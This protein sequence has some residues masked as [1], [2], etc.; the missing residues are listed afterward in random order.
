[1]SK[2]E[3][4]RVRH[5][6]RRR[7][8]TVSAVER[9]TPQMLRITLTSPDLHD[10]VSASFDDHVKLIFPGSDDTP[11]MREYTP[12]SFDTAHNTL[13][14]DFALHEAGPATQWA[15]SAKVGDNLQIGGP[16]GSAVIPDD[17]DWYLLVGDETALPAIGRRLEELRA[18]VPVASVVIG[19]AQTI[20]TKANWTPHWISRDGSSDDATLLRNA[21]DKHV[22][23]HG[24]GFVWIA[25]EAA[26]ARSLRSYIIETRGHPKAWTKAAAY[27]TRGKADTSEKSI[28]D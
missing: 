27:W 22:L 24:E 28:E 2:H 18:G 11:V 6:L 12:R 19:D 13:V 5:D 20:T 9:L 26:A 7:L 25:A 15:A 23:P 21:L 8:L 3:I 1:M 10:F 16:R 17:F 14:I 4:T